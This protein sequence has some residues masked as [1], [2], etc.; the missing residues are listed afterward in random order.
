MIKCQVAPGVSNKKT[1]VLAS[2]RPWNRSMAT[3]L[4]ARL[5][6][7]F[8]LISDPAELT[9]ENLAAVNPSLVFLPHWSHRIDT[10]VYEQFECVIFHM[11]DLP[12]GRGG[13]PLQNL[14]VRGIY[15]T[16]ISAIRCVKEM[17]AGPVYVKR[18]LRAPSYMYY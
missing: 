7:D 9:C 2:S 5:G 10:D 4:C 16:C 13:S 17:D 12:Y 14:I 1:Y 3:R 6:A 8:V 18:A 15:E 11:T